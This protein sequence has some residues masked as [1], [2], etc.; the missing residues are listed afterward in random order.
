MTCEWTDEM[1]EISGFGGDYEAAC[2]NMVRA[3]VKW[4]DEH[5][6]SEPQF[7]G[8]KNITGII[9]D[10]N[11]DAR[12]LS[13]AIV[14]ACHDCSGAMHQAAVSHVLAIKRLGWEKYSEE[15]KQREAKRSESASARTD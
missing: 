10:D 15:M 4:F 6:E 14:D 8:Y 11:D 2:R 1:G 5:P 12:S 13:V 7:H 9:V 3:G